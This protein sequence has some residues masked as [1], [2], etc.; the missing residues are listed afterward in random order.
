MMQS[1][2][3]V[4]WSIICC[5]YLNSPAGISKENTVSVH[6]Y[7]GFYS[8]YK[9]PYKGINE[10]SF[11]DTN[12]LKNYYV[13][14]KDNQGNSTSFKK[15]FNNQCIFEF[16]YKYDHNNKLLETTKTSCQEDS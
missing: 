8:N 9:H 5:L 1:G 2:K 4:H 6:Y 3:I 13:E 15:T 14:E 11:A 12:G 7:L 16:K 10:I